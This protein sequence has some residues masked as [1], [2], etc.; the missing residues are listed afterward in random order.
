MLSF[1]SEIMMSLIG[2]EWP[3]LTHDWVSAFPVPHALYPTGQSDF[4]NFL[5]GLSALLKGSPSLLA[6]ILYE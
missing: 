5:V 3:S 1:E 2:H 4:P 6:Q